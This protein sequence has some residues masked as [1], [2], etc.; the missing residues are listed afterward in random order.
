[1]TLDVLAYRPNRFTI[2]IVKQIFDLTSG[3][4]SQ[5]KRWKE[6][7]KRICRQEF[8]TRNQCFIIMRRKKSVWLYEGSTMY[9]KTVKHITA[10][11][12]GVRFLFV[13]VFFVYKKTTGNGVTDGGY[14]PRHACTT[15][16][17]SACLLLP[18][19]ASQGNA[20]TMCGSG[21][22]R[23]W[24]EPGIIRPGAWWRLWQRRKEMTKERR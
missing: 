7:L 19:P 16:M 9:W 3:L 22:I 2:M 4:F 20:S 17:S 8:D 15:V 1:M 14:L 10:E 24:V 12:G 5:V 18:S 23:S 11:T 21:R 6:L 13:A